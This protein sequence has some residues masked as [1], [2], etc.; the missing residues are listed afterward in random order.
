MHN[1]VQA[2]DLC[3]IDFAD[4]FDEGRMRKAGATDVKAGDKAVA[5]TAVFCHTLENDWPRRARNSCIAA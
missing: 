2:S 5:D 4:V 1:G 3:F